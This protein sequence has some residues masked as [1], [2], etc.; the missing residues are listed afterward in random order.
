MNT[1]IMYLE[2]SST[3]ILLGTNLRVEIPLLNSRL[4]KNYLLV[5]K[6]LLVYSIGLAIDYLTF[7]I[8]NLG[9]SVC[10]L[11]FFFEGNSIILKSLLFKNFISPAFFGLNVIFNIMIKIFLGVSLLNRFDG[12]SLLNSLSYSLHKLFVS[13]KNFIWFSVISP[14]LGRIT[15]GELGF[16]PNI[17]SFFTY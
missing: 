11:K 10:Y 7:P 15:A 8:K 5:N 12:F 9:N 14:Y 16:L 13:F 6:Q 17:Q 2:N 1:T 4:R 3:I